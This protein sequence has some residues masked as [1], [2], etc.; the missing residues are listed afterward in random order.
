MLQKRDMQLVRLGVRRK[1]LTPEEGEDLLF[2]KRKF[3]DKY[4]IEEI[5]RRRQY[6]E[7]DAIVELTK[8]AE[9]LVRRRGATAIFRRK[10]PA[11]PKPVSRRAWRSSPAS[12]SI[13]AMAAGNVI[14][15][16]SLPASLAWARVAA[17][18]FH[19][20][21]GAVGSPVGA[22]PGFEFLRGVISGDESIIF[23]GSITVAGVVGPLGAL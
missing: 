9:K 10:P 21:M 6:L 2:L 20:A 3:G 5:I 18:G 1:W 14:V 17:A 22:Y 7:D 8:A 12:S 19:V 23:L 11:P 13:S 4:T 16:N 15:W